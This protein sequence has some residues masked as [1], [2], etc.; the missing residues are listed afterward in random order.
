M[1]ASPDPHNPYDI[2]SHRPAEAC[3]ACTIQQ[4]RLRCRFSWGH[5]AKFAVPAFVAM[6]LGG[7]GLVL[8]GYWWAL[9]VWVG[10]M[11][12][13]F[14]VWEIRVLC[15]HCPYY[16]EEGRTL[17]CIANYSSLK[18]WKYH[19]EPMNRWESAQFLGGALFFVVWPFPFLLAGG[20]GVI[21]A[22]VGVLFLGW[23]WY[24]IQRICHECV[25]FSCPLNRVP[26]PVVDAY[27]RQNTV[28]REAWEA[29]GY[30]LDDP[31]TKG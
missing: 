19:P 11:L 29:S 30:E 4:G 22:V 31:A 24:L 17:R 12:V 18:L 5:L 23:G 26:K 7:V 28:M 1:S 15:S 3:A 21:T 14:E 20:Q 10:F 2:C 9:A 16:A 25:N 8:A 6:I 27:L 13:F